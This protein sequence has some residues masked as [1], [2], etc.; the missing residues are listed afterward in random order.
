MEG[1][2]DGQ[3]SRVSVSLARGTTGRLMLECSPVAIVIA[4][5]SHEGGRVERELSVLK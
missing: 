1:E 2:T 5:S 4:G 3:S